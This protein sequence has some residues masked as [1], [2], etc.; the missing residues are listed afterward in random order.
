MIQ[1]LKLEEY[2]KLCKKLE[3]QNYHILAED[4]TVYDF[5]ETFEKLAKLLPKMEKKGL[6]LFSRHP[7][8][9]SHGG[10]INNGQDQRAD[11]Q[12]ICSQGINIQDTGIRRRVSWYY[13]ADLWSC[14][15]I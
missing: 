3:L 7:G 11:A 8:N 2:L 15:C 9:E 13:L 6:P 4:K 1:F 5:I 12:G 14:Y 10:N